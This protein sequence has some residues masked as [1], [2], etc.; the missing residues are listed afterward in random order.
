[1]EK[2][3]RILVIAVNFMYTRYI[4]IVVFTLWHIY[5]AGLEQR[6]M[7]KLRRNDFYNCLLR[8][9]RKRLPYCSILN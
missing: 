5:S 3:T 2:S 8:G 1:M 6:V 4:Y 9:E 7:L